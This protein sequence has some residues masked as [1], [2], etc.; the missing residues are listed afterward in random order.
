MK[1]F[2]NKKPYDSNF[3]TVRAAK[4]EGRIAAH[5]GCLGIKGQITPPAPAFMKGDWML[6]AAL[7]SYTS[8][9]GCSLMVNGNFECITP[10]EAGTLVGSPLF[11]TGYVDCT[12]CGLTS[13]V[14]AP[15][16]VR[17][18]FKCTFNPL[19]SFEGIPLYIGGSI[20][21]DSEIITEQIYQLVRD[22]IDDEDDDEGDIDFEY[23]IRQMMRA[24][25]NLYCREIEFE[26]Y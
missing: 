7:G 11:V 20:M 23:Y 4:E 18:D 5:P 2:K 16:Y 22:D 3:F 17:K 13:L 8:L 21:F 19:K 1:L 26:E 10:I 12:G 15:L 6:E 25:G 9:Q 14:G 24:A